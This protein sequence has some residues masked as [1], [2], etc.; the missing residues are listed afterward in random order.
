MKMRSE[1]WNEASKS[2]QQKQKKKTEQ[3]QFSFAEGA[4]F[5]F[6]DLSD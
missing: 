3:F 1:N 4:A 6:L 5:E 2:Y